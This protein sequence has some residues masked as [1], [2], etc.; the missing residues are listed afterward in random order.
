MRAHT[1]LDGAAHILTQAIA[2]MHT[3]TIRCHPLML[4]HKPVQTCTPMLAYI[5]H[6]PVPRCMHTYMHANMHACIDAY[7]R[8][9]MHAHVPAYRNMRNH[10]YP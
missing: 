6:M 10:E 1:H 9:Q 8:A 3:R 7:M 4:A 5:G 2:Q